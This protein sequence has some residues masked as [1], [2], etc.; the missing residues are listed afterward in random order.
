MG[1]RLLITGG[2]LFIINP[3][4]KNTPKQ[5]KRSAKKERVEE[6]RTLLENTYSFENEPFVNVKPT[7]DRPRNKYKAD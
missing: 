7:Y 1:N 6:E 4:M 5:R 2:F 3:P